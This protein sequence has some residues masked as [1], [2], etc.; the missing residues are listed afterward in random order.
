MALPPTTARPLR[1]VQIAP[2]P[3]LPMSAGGKIRIVQLA[4]ALCRLGVELTIVA[5]FHVTQKK[6]LVEQ[7]PFRLCQLPYPPF[8]LHYL[9]V[10]RPFPYGALVSFHPGYKEMLPVKLG[11]FDVC[12]VDHPAFVDLVADLPASVPVVYGAQN[13]EF[14]YVSSECG[15]DFVRQL[16]GERIR[17]LESKLIERSAHVFACTERDAHRFSELYHVPAEKVSV[18]RNGVDLSEVD[19]E[20]AR[21]N[22]AHGGPGGFKLCAV[23]TGS[24]VKHNRDAVAIILD[25]I[26]PQLEREVE[27]V[28]VG[29]C[30]RRFMDQQRPNV[31]YDPDGNLASYARPGVV[32]LDPVIAGSGSSMKVLHYLACDLPVLSTPFGMRGYEDLKPWV[33]TAELDDFPA[34]LRRGLPTTPGLRRQMARYEWDTMADQAL[35]VYEALTGRPE[36][37]PRSAV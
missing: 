9:L 21:Q 26:A 7:E 3:I 19:A 11:S 4:R 17:S 37:V 6:A 18:I 33:V 31:R 2:Y 22:G 1:L 16:A 12:Q 25:R 23:L 34:L 27:F 10:D 35:R 24:D 5:P 13:V 20:R 32:G 28:I 36:R 8:V 30:A 29:P 15:S 14:D